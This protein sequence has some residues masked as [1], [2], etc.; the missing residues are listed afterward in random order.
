VYVCTC[1]Y[2]MMNDGR[3]PSPAGV[4]DFLYG[5]ECSSSFKIYKRLNVAKRTR[6]NHN[7]LGCAVYIFIHTLCDQVD[8]STN[9]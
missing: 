7:V 8:S 9:G 4:W 5:R 2:W 3:Q 1:A 6:I